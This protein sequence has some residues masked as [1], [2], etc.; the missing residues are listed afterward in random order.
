[1]TLD[2]YLDEE[3]S[4]EMKTE[5]EEN[6]NAEGMQAVGYS[7]RLRPGALPSRL[8]GTEASLDMQDAPFTTFHLFA[9]SW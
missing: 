3:F 2:E 6:Q 4:K 9:S 1:M 8:G 7:L 5:Q